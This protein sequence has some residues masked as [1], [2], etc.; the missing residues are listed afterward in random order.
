MTLTIS[1]MMLFACVS[2]VTRRVQRQ[3]AVVAVDI[4][5]VTMFSE[6]LQVAAMFFELLRVSATFSELIQVSATFSV[7]LRV[8]ATFFELPHRER[9]RLL[10]WTENSS[11]IWLISILLI[12]ANLSI[13]LLPYWR[14]NRSLSSN[15]IAA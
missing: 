1:T 8:A 6:L 13:A 10:R 9:D 2:A 3:S 14:Q 15:Q 7:L 11:V 4:R 12:E 5:V